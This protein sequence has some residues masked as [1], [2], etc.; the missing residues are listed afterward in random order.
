MGKLIRLV[1]VLAIGMFLGYIFHD[2]I[3]VKVKDW[4]GT[5]RVEKGKTLVEDGATKLITK[6]DG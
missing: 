3:D 2:P 4:F 6:E 5:Q 1:L